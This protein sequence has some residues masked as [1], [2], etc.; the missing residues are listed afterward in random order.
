M[1][2]ATNYRVQIDELPS[3]PNDSHPQL[4]NNIDFTDLLGTIRAF[5]E[6]PRNLDTQEIQRLQDNINS[7]SQILETTGNIP[8]NVNLQTQR[9]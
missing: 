7:I 1:N 6:N 2:I 5:Q 9:R 3:G 8:P 4:I